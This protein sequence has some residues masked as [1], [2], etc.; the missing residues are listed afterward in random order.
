MRRDRWPL[1]RKLEKEL[2]DFGEA[3]GVRV[4]I[5]R[6]A[7]RVYAP[8]DSA[9]SRRAKALGNPCRVETCAEAEPITRVHS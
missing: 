5:M 6:V 2:V 7:D 9:L 4:V 3:N 1:A 8:A